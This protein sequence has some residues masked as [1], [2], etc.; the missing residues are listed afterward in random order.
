[1]ALKQTPGQTTQHLPGSFGQAAKKRPAQSTRPAAA[2]SAQPANH[3]PW[4]VGCRG[5]RYPKPA[6]PGRPA[7]LRWLSASATPQAPAIVAAKV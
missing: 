4:M 7:S 3:H 6:S 1:M 2:W 5:V